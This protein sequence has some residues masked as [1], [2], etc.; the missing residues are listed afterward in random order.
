[1]LEKDKLVNLINLTEKLK[2]VKDIQK[3]LEED[4]QMWISAFTKSDVE[5][6]IPD[7]IVNKDT[8]GM[9]ES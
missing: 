3:S 7:S 2:C 4:Q 6:H 1:V 8:L 9:G 5:N